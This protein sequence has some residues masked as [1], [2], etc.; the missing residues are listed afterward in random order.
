LPPTLHF[1]IFYLFKEHFYFFNKFF[2]VFVF[3]IKHDVIAQFY[4]QS[5]QFIGRK[6]IILYMQRKEINNSKDCIPL[7][8]PHMSVFQL[9][10][11]S[12]YE[13]GESLFLYNN[14][15]A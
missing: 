13:L 14:Y 6:F 7:L 15:I 4:K 10:N 12:I 2:F 8:L 11:I 9:V 3:Y 1:F 5:L